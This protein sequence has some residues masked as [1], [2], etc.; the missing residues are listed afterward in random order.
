MPLPLPSC[1]SRRASA[2]P[3]ACAGFT[4]IELIV[5]M[6]IMLFIVSMTV[7]AF[8]PVFG[9]AGMKSAAR[10][11]TACLDGARVRAIHQRRFVRFEAQRVP[12]V[13]KVQWRV[14]SSGGEVGQE[15]KA[16]PE[17]VVVETN[18]EALASGDTT[19]LGGTFSSA[20]QRIAVTFGPDGSVARCS[21]GINSEQA[22]GTKLEPDSPFGL[23]LTS[24]RDAASTADRP[25]K[26]VALIPLTG[27]IEIVE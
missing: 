24:I 5:S 27:A 6:G 3:R 14:T 19:G 23:R 25:T 9:S 4:L 8:A 10:L 12:G 21:V 16:L 15:W 20:N 26:W 2:S 7:L 11:V 17:F 18:V 13:N 1:L 22:F